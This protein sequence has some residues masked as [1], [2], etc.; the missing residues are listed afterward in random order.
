[1][2]IVIVGGGT[3]GWLV[4][5][6]LATVRPQ[7]T[8]T[9]IDSTE[10]P[11]VGVGEAVTGKFVEVLEKCGINLLDFMIATDALPKHGIRFTNWLSQP[12][13]FDSPLE[14]SVSHRNYLDDRL[15]LQ[16]LKNQPIEYASYSGFLTVNNR[17]SWKLEGDQLVNTFFHA[18]QFDESKAGNYL[19]QSAIARG[20]KHIQETIVSVAVDQGKIKEIC[21]KEGNKI[22]A[23]L[24]IDCS[25]IARLLISHLN[26]GFKD[27]SQ[28]VNV[29]SAFM[30][31]VNDY[32]HVPKCYV[33]SIARN[34]GWNF[35]ISSRRRMGRGYLYNSSIA[36]K[37]NIIE[38]L[39]QV[40][41]PI[42]EVKSI[43]W[44]PGSLEKVWI[45]NVIAIGLSASFL[46]P[47]QAGTIHDCLMQATDLAETSL[48]D[49]P[50]EEIITG[51]NKRSQRLFDDYLDLINVC[52]ATDREDTD[53]WKF[54]KYQQ[55]ITDRA[56]NIL[57]LA[58]QR[59]TRELD[60]DK[61]MGY[62]SQGLYNYTL[63]GLD[64]FKTKTIA[65][66]MS[67]SWNNNS[68]NLN[69]SNLKNS[70]HY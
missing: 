55:K 43:H 34:N 21:T 61:F 31:Q 70:L 59:L 19:K 62:G 38:E 36:T 6:Y 54:V 49:H 20:I 29:N 63:A 41:G 67:I 22:Q 24:F 48:V 16:L 35:E 68:N 69:N 42:T 11:T 65:V 12:G 40:Y 8:Y 53:F 7:H 32:L 25:G 9:T 57:D 14:Y 30:F 13:H 17:C 46:E 44:T 37:D 64:L 1:M 52:Y 26:P 60:F 33:N 66:S 45:G 5:L 58:Q 28:Y 3:A 4:S 27:C 50:T 23:D 47:L 51:F 39:T 10:V 18:L 56:E 15:Y 2:N